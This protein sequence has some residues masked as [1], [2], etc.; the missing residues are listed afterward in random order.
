MVLDE[1]HDSM[2]GSVNG[3]AVL[4]CITEI[5]P[6]RLFLV[7]ADMVGMAHKLIDTLILGR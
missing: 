4:I 1:V 7:L 5:L 6:Q 2:K 3:T